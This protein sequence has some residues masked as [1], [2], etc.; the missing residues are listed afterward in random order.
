MINCDE[1]I[2]DNTRKNKGTVW[3]NFET[4]KFEFHNLSTEEE[5][6][7]FFDDKLTKFKK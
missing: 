7:L 4:N 3:I 2:L 5:M 1:C 6:L